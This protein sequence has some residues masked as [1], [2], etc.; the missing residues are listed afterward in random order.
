V[1]DEAGIVIHVAPDCED[2]NASI[3]RSEGGDVGTGHGWWL[4]A[5]C[6][7]YLPKIEI[8]GYSSS[9]GRE[10]VVIQDDLPGLIHFRLPPSIK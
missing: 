9:I 10:A 5:L 1:Q 4:D 8:P 6:I 3:F 2:W 7:G